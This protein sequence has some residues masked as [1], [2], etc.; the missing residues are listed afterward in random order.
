VDGEASSK[1]ENEGRGGVGDGGE[2][3]GAG[4]LFPLALISTTQKTRP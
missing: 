1:S 2:V 3:T 4:I